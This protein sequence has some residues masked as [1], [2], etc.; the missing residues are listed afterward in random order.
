MI[1]P[2]IK[3]DEEEKRRKKTKATQH[4]TTRRKPTL[5]DRCRILVGGK[6]PTVVH[7]RV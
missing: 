1:V 6:T 4:Q 7:D 3:R 2:I 5:I